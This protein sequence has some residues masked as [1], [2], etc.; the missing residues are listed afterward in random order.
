MGTIILWAKFMLGLDGQT[1]QTIM[2]AWQKSAPFCAFHPATFAVAG[3]DDCKQDMLT[4]TNSYTPQGNV[5]YQS[6][7]PQ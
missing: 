2:D 3:F 4:G 6:F 5:F 1:R 7:P